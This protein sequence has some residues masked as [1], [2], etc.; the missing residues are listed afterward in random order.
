M[1]ATHRSSL[2]PL[3]AFAAALGAT[4]CG[5][6]AVF[7]T[8]SLEVR[9]VLLSDDMLLEC[10]EVPIVSALEIS[11]LNATETA[12]RA[13]F[14]RQVPCGPILVEGPEGPSR[15]SIQALGTVDQD[16]AATLFQARVDVALPGPSEIVT[17]RPEVAFVNLDWNFGERG[18]EPCLNE[19]ARID[20]IVAKPGAGGS[21]FNQSFG[22]TD[23]PVRIERPFSLSSHTID[24]RAVSS[25]G[26]PSYARTEQQVFDRGTNQ[27]LALLSPQGG[28]LLLD[29]QFELDGVI[30]QACDDLDVRVSTVR[31]SVQGLTLQEGVLVPD[32]SRAMA[33]DLD[34]AAARPVPF[35]PERFTAQ[36]QL[37]VVLEA[38]GARHRFRSVDRIVMPEGDALLDPS[39]LTAVGVAT[40]TVAAV[41]PDC[42]AMS[43]EAVTLEIRPKGLA[44]VTAT[45]GRAGGAALLTVPNLPYGAYDVTAERQPALPRC[46]PVTVE[47]SIRARGSDWGLVEL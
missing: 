47:R 25:G 34:C 37:E 14:P 24:V 5:D 36:R 42:D 21:A 10:S 23:R 3:A 2:T 45:A 46:P 1:I 13:G 29:W 15:L 8:S 20:V 32:G 43:A 18:L 9:P 11:L 17:L 38:D 35:L 30:F 16:P 4:G 6:D 22:C 27:V 33:Q 31:A 19:V 7:P 44:T 12:P 26:F 41:S 39:V 28:Q 40:A